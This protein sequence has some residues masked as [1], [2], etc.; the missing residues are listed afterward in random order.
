MSVPLDSNPYSA[1]KSNVEVQRD[2]EENRKRVDAVVHR[3]TTTNKGR[4]PDWDKT[5]LMQ[6]DRMAL[7]KGK[8]CIMWD[9]QKHGFFLLL[10][11]DW[12]KNEPVQIKKGQ[13]LLEP[14]WYSNAAAMLRPPLLDPELPLNQVAEWVDTNTM[15]I[16]HHLLPHIQDIR[17][18]A[19][20]GKGKY[21]LSERNPYWQ[22][23]QCLK[24][25]I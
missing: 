1:L 4:V 7:E 6:F 16:H 3:M 17:E 14:G 12:I 10:N 9:D 19:E 24:E 8:R 21:C 11:W 15:K 2:R 18:E 20:D 5:R 13:N 22:E 23:L 25:T